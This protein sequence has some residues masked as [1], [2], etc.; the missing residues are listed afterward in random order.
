MCDALL[1]P[2]LNQTQAQKLIDEL[3]ENLRNKIRILD[4]KFDLQQA[5]KT[6]TNVQKRF[7]TKK[8]ILKKISDSIYLINAEKT[9]KIIG[10]NYAFFKEL[11]GTDFSPEKVVSE[12]RDSYPA[13]WEKLLQNHEAMGLLYGFGKD[14]IEVFQRNLNLGAAQSFSTD[15]KIDIFEATPNNF[16]IPVFVSQRNHPLVQLYEKEKLEIGRIYQGKDML[17]TSLEELTR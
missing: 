11:L 10:E 16:S 14:N 17:S 15:E 9:A 4:L 3:P 13:H 5:W 1:P 6:W 2:Q 7:H 12:L 8:Y